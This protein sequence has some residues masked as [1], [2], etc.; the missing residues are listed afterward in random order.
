MKKMVILVGCIVA[1]SGITMAEAPSSIE[2]KVEK[3]IE[4]TDRA[5]WCDPLMHFIGICKS[6]EKLPTDY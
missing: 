6:S 1:L 3:K 2:E 4:T 5:W